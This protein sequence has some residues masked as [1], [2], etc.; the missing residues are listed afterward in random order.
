M[1]EGSRI[2]S[3]LRITADPKRWRYM[4]IPM[5]SSSTRPTDLVTAI[6][7]TESHLPDHTIHRIGGRERNYMLNTQASTYLPITHQ[8]RAVVSFSK[9]WMEAMTDHIRLSRTVLMR[10]TYRLCGTIKMVSSFAQSLNGLY[11]K[12]RNFTTRTREEPK[13]RCLSNLRW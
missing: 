3:D 6:H 13:R 9:A 11:L 10:T 2:W 1:V 8:S 12:P 5:A 7:T 4:T